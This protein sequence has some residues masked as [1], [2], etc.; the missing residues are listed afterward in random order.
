MQRSTHDIVQGATKLRPFI[1]K[2]DEKRG[3]SVNACVVLAEDDWQFADPKAQPNACLQLGSRWRLMAAPS[4]AQD[5]AVACR[6][7]DSKYG[8]GEHESPVNRVV[9]GL[10]LI[11][12]KLP[13]QF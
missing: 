6:P 7:R 4:D 8:K 3:L 5:A 10:R 2:I 13:E 1:G 11:G 12:F 9:I